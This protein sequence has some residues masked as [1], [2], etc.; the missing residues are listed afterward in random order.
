MDD[1]MNLKQFLEQDAKKDAAVTP[2]L[3]KFLRN[4]EK[5][6]LVEAIMLGSNYTISNQ[7]K[8]VGI[9]LTGKC[10]TKKR[11]ASILLR[12][13]HI[14]SPDIPCIKILRDSLLLYVHMSKSHDLRSLSGAGHSSC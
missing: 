2:T 3:D 1:E 12:M 7:G 11:N 8:L 6:A 14:L 5:A 9:F 4:T 13:I 10:M